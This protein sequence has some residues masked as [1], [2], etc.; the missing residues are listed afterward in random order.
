MPK[1]TCV[2]HFWA[3]NG[4]RR[5]E[6]R[7]FHR[8]HPRQTHPAEAFAW[9][10]WRR[11]RWLCSTAAATCAAACHVPPPSS[12]APRARGCVHAAVPQSRKS[13]GP[14]VPRLTHR[15]VS[16]GSTRASDRRRRR[17]LGQRARLPG[18]PCISYPTYH[19]NK[20]PHTISF[21]SRS[22]ARTKTVVNF[23]SKS[24]NITV[25]R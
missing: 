22:K 15:S 1:T 2:H 5:R 8:L 6:I 23:E 10:V 3:E 9:C 18:E 19:K 24:Y 14:T 21:A 20:A 25:P 12:M 13:S 11:R 17:R 7:R 4:R 16:R